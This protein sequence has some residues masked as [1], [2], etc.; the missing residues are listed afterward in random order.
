MEPRSDL[1][2][3]RR[4]WPLPALTAVVAALAV[5]V[6]VD[7]GGAYPGLFAGPGLTADEGFNASQG[8]MLADRLLAVDLAGF[9]KIDAQLPDHPPLG[10]IWLGLCHEL[11]FVVFPPVNA[12]AGYSIACARAGSA[13]AYAATVFLIGLCA[14]RWYGRGA[15]L[16]AASALILS[17]RLFGHAHLAALETCINLAYSAVVF[18]L[19][20]RSV[21]NERGEIPDPRREIRIGAIAGVLFGLA[22]LTK[23]QA[24]FLPLPFGAWMLFVWR[25]RAFAPLA[26]FGLIGL[27]IFLVG[28]PWLWEHPWDR[29]M[30]Y[31]GRTTDRATIYV[32]Y[33]GKVIADRDVPWHYPWLIFATTVPIGL[34][35]LGVL[36]VL[37]AP[38]QANSSQKTPLP[39][40]G[41]GV[42]S[43]LAAS[44]EAPPSIPGPSP[45]RGEGRKIPWGDLAFW[46]SPRESLVLL[47]ATFPLVMFSLPGVAVYD[48]ERLFSVVYPL[49]CVFIGRGAV[50]IHAAMKQRLSSTASQI[51]MAVLIC[52]QAVGLFTAAP[53]WL[54]Y[55]NLSI[56]GLRGA[57]R[58]GLQVTYWGDSLTRDLL[59]TVAEQVPAGGTVCVA[60]TLHQFQWSE[61]VRQT[62]VLRQRE[63]KFVPYD[64]RA[65]A[66]EYLLLFRRPEYLPESLRG[67][68]NAWEEIAA[69]RREGVVLA[70]LL[71]QKSASVQA[72]A[73]RDLTLP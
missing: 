65:P 2:S 4:H 60:P 29:T 48:G 59:R 55:Y 71:K 66:S 9:R 1:S 3:Q 47:C 17:P 5:W 19:A 54:S 43:V 15:G 73:G 28:W 10:R 36:G 38:K 50:A 41:G 13:L 49:W 46:K 12:E 35:L 45:A 32:W 64:E 62:P 34:H 16:V 52:L 69:V 42:A 25:R 68:W 18:W 11:A 53:C 58:L 40:D 26:L 61:L 67:D 44:S 23:I 51:A 63:L 8:V 31:L 70:A 57:E 7:S 14:A 37:D 72:S 30:Q 33:F 27:T 22:L 56:G 20:D 24:I 39:L 21:A 6:T